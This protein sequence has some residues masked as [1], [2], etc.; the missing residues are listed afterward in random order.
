MTNGPF[1]PI[2]TPAKPEINPQNQSF[3][4][5]ERT[6]LSKGTQ[7]KNKIVP[8][9]NQI[10]TYSDSEPNKKIAQNAPKIVA[11]RIFLMSCHLKNSL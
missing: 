3:L 5:I 10:N 6:K 7:V 8:A 4:M 11:I 9:I 1:A 2:K